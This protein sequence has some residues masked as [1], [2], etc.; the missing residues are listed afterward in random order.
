MNSFRRLPASVPARTDDYLALLP[1]LAKA[2]PAAVIESAHALW[3]ESGSAVA[4][5]PGSD[6]GPGHLRYV[7]GTPGRR[8]PPTQDCR[9][10]DYM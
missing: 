10:G 6:S 3:R 2:E 5:N 7:L 9:P 1:V 8:G 4:D